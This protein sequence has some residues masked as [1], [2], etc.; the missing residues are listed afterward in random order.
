[1]NADETAATTED[2]FRLTIDTL[3]GFVYTAAPD[4]TIEFS[5][6]QLLA[7][8]GITQAEAADWGR[9]IH[10]D[11][12]DRVMSEW[13]DSIAKGTK[14][15]FVLRACRFDGVYRWLHTRLVPLLRDNRVVR[16]YGLVTDVDDLKQTEERLR[17]SEAFLL[18]AQR[19]SHCGSWAHDLATGKVAC[20]PEM[21]RI[22]GVRP[23][24]DASTVDFWIERVHPDDRQ[25][26]V[27]AF[28]A[29]ER[30][31]TEYRADYRVVLPDG[32]IRFIHSSGVPLLGARGEL[33]EFI[34]TSVDI[35]EQWRAR[36]DLERAFEALR[37]TEFRLAQAM[38]IATVGELAAA[39]AHEVNQPLAAVVTNAHACLR[40]LSAQP[41]DLDEARAASERIVR[42]GKA[43]GEVI[44]RVRSLFQRA[45]V[46]RSPLEINE[47][48]GEVLRLIARELERSQT[49]VDTDLDEQLP[50][51]MGDRIQLQQV[52]LNLLKNALDATA[53]VVD[54]PRT[55]LVA[56][57][58]DGN[59]ALI[60]VRDAGVGIQDPEKAF[61][62]FYTTKDGGMGIGLAICRSIVEAHDG[63]IWVAARDEKGTTVR[64]TV[65]LCL[66]AHA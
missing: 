41:P 11:D 15:D 45:T 21:L 7:F 53:L 57:R 18:E 52:V 16:W 20:S 55:L 6:Q 38:R 65:P 50:S 5:N 63:K 60:E 23:E 37:T 14:L 58:R 51:V 39:I 40:W 4:G 8:L 61:E 1:V 54:R 3:P 2:G 22:A 17:R 10:P 13:N 31:V 33:L 64:F 9:L 47:V 12:V 30:E 42:D 44:H 43:A 26:V 46:E 27:E 49:T 48:I 24:E 66:E 62:A 28:G 59:H 36:V 56:S 29:A 25:Q 32:S 34:G 19:M 35:T